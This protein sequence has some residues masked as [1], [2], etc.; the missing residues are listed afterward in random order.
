MTLYGHHVLPDPWAALVLAL[1][2]YRIVRLIGWDDFP[3]IARIRAW[4]TGEHEMVVGSF[5]DRLGVT[6]TQPSATIAYQR[7]MLAHFLHC[8]FCQGWWV[9]LAVFVAWSL[10]PAWTLIALAPFAL[11]AAVGLIARNLDP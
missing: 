2:V 3:P 4:A 1:G 5:N 8:P 11:S 7:P 9:S 6:Q 10:V